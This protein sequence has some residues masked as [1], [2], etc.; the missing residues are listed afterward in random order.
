MTSSTS[1]V[2][3]RPPEGRDGLGE[4]EE[5]P[6]HSPYKGLS[7]YEEH[8][9]TYFFGRETETRIVEAN[10]VAS[11]LTVLYGES[12]VGK[13]SLLRAGVAHRLT[14]AARRNIR[15][16]G[17]PRALAVVY[18]STEG[19]VRISWRD[20]PVPRILAAF[21][22][23]AVGLGIEVAAPD[24]DLGF[25]EALTA[26]TQSLRS[27]LLIVLDQFEEYLLYHEGEEGP[28]TLAAELPRAL[29]EPNLRVNFLLSIRED[30]LA[31][32]DVFKRTIPAIF[33]NCVRVN[34][35]AREDARKAITKPIDRYNESIEQ[36]QKITIE[37][38]LVDTLLTELETGRVLLGLSGAGISEMEA[39]QSD[40]PVET[41]F[42]QLVMT[43]LWSEERRAQSRDLRLATLVRLGH[44]ER[45]IKTHLD[46][47]MRT[48]PRYARY[49]AACS[50]H[51]LVT[52]SGSKIAHTSEDLA[53]Y[54][55][56][57]E[58][59]VEPTLSRLTEA[60]YRILR[61]VASATDE[62]APG[63]FEIF[64]DVLG[65]PI[66]DWRLRYLRTRNVVSAIRRAIVALVQVL[67]GAFCA[68]VLAAALLD[69]QN[70]A[71][72]AWAAGAVVVWVSATFVLIRRWRRR[73]AWAVPLV[74]A[75]AALIGLVTAPVY[76]VNSLVR[77]GAR[78]RQP[79][80]V[81]RERRRRRPP[82]AARSPL[83]LRR[84]S[85]GSV[86]FASVLVLVACVLPAVNYYDF[87]G[88][89]LHTAHLLGSGGDVWYA[90]EPL[91][92]AGV[93]A[94]VGV[95]A[96]ALP[97]SRQFARGLLSGLS[98][99]A[100]AYFTGLLFWTNG[101]WVYVEQRS[102][103]SLDFGTQQA[104]VTIGVVG[105][106]LMLVAAAPTAGL[107]IFTEILGFGNKLAAPRRSTLPPVHAP[108]RRI[109][110]AAL[111]LLALVAAGLAFAGAFV[112]TGRWHAGQPSSLFAISFWTGWQVAV[113]AV[114]AMVTALAILFSRRIN[115]R[116]AGWL[117]GFGVA[118]MALF[119]G[120]IGLRHGHAGSIYL[121]LVSGALLLLA[122][123][124]A[125][126]VT[127]LASKPRDLGR[128]YAARD[129]DSD[130]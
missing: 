89:H 45:I 123:G 14:S 62:D 99:G 7:Y 94:L 43:R 115:A 23:L 10:L 3:A 25:C 2:E 119:G 48:L 105:A 26:W 39:G 120:T 59:E 35:L 81:R 29:S 65:P 37:K 109:V 78:Q 128:T 12:G 68:I 114:A 91:V 19:D 122:G 30:Q 9:A 88:F 55:G 46:A 87:P 76:L 74:G 95:L 86:L 124:V 113:P 17:V 82:R 101:L 96:L 75:V 50:F 73:E 121:G 51:H 4:D 6:R 97:R 56:L 108:T 16:T 93:A 79:R 104:A 21:E 34:H 32:L 71:V 63:R 92:G 57:G 130:Y 33:E 85:A 116:A 1:V 49:V 127:A 41:P 52:P 110:R 60:D 13:T 36:S 53:A 42:L 106:A 11:R 15:R 69:Q 8:D 61:R 18:P 54:T 64:H 44:S 125:A 47:T 102:P 117:A 80:Q 67:V 5:R 126:M 84:F 111:G 66:L 98:L 20:S 107:D 27:D 24:P 40:R 22:Q 118:L 90:L 31:R 103:S 28:G 72:V 58:D 129:V 70:A 83:P 112:S 38:E 77:V 100:L